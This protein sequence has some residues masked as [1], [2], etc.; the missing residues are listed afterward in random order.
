MYK[1]TEQMTPMSWILSQTT[2][3]NGAE[4]VSLALA[5]PAAL[6]HYIIDE[7]R[8]LWARRRAIRGVVGVLG[9]QS[10]A[11]ALL[12]GAQNQVRGLSQLRSRSSPL[13]SRR[14]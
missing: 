6:T 11:E 12:E 14:R 3:E 13:T 10:W 5:A 1:L 7:D 9:R 8:C 4:G 2:R